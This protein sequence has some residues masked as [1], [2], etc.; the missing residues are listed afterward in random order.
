MVMI[1]ILILTAEHVQTEGRSWEER[2][3]FFLFSGLCQ[4]QII[5]QKAQGRSLSIFGPEVAG[6]ALGEEGGQCGF[7]VPQ[8]IYVQFHGGLGAG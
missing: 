1:V 3:I 7:A 6:S 2:D 8:K 4:V 5:K